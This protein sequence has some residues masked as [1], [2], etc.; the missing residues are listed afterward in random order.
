M[1]VRVRVRNR[2][3][4]IKRDRYGKRERDSKN[5]RESVTDCNRVVAN[6]IN[7]KKT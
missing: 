4:D 1:T 5:E 7:L 6:W 3:A 2:Q